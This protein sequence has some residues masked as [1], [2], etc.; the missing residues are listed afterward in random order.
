MSGLDQ[1]VYELKQLN[2]MPV[3]VYQLSFAIKL[4]RY[5]F[6]IASNRR[7]SSTVFVFDRWVMQ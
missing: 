5:D 2:A 6:R 3:R 4:A 7:H 1:T